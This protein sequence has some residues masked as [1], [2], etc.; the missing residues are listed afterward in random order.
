MLGSPA[1]AAAARTC[2]ASKS[3][4]R[5]ARARGPG[6]E[7]GRSWGLRTLIQRFRKQ[8][9][10]AQL[11]N[12]GTQKVVQRRVFTRE[13]CWF[14]VFSLHL[15]LN[16]AP[17]WPG[18]VPGSARA[19]PSRDLVPVTCGAR[20]AVPHASVH[21]K[22][23]KSW[24][25]FQSPGRTDTIKSSEYPHFHTAPCC[26]AFSGRRSERQSAK[27]ESCIRNFLLQTA[28]LLSHFH[29]WRAANPRALRVRV[30]PQR[31]VT[32]SLTESE[33]KKEK[34]EKEK[35]PEAGPLRAGSVRPAARGRTGGCRGAGAHPRGG[36]GARP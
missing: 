25:F 16:R 35:D 34:K 22:D 13:R 33:K 9:V 32:G 4:R 3:A 5:R 15:E 31:R 23:K 11:V 19:R 24:R 2:V 21:A 7:P 8:S 1:A 10:P 26:R 14:W 18:S 12:S 29:G 6:L 36:P 27:E 17:G 30:R 28:R 20:P